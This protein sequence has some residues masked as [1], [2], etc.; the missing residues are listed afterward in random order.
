MASMATAATPAATTSLAMKTS[1]SRSTI[2]PTVRD[3]SVVDRI[4][5]T[6][7]AMPNA[8]ASIIATR[9]GSTIEVRT[10]AATM[11]TAAMTTWMKNGVLVS[12]LA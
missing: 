9:A 11:L 4:E 7:Y 2:E 8:N 3:S 10:I 1:I 6:T 12:S 5:P